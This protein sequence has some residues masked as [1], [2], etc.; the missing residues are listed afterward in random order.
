MSAQHCLRMLDPRFYL[1]WQLACLAALP[2]LSMGWILQATPVNHPPV[3][4]FFLPFEGVPFVAG[5][6]LFFQATADDPEDAVLQPSAFNWRIELHRGSVT[7][8]VLESVRGTTNGW[9]EI[10]RAPE[11]SPGS[12]Y[13]VWLTVTD[14][15]GLSTS[16]FRDVFPRTSVFSLQ[17]DPPGLPL[18]LDG[19]RVETSLAITGV[20]GVTRSLGVVS[21]V[22]MG[23]STYEFI[24]WSDRGAPEHEILTPWEPLVYWITVGVG[25]RLPGNPYPGPTA[26]PWR[27]ELLA[28]ETVVASE[29]GGPVPWQGAFQDANLNLNTEEL[30][31]T[32]LS[33]PLRLR[34][35]AASSVP[36]A[37]LD[38]DDVRVQVNGLSVNGGELSFESPSL[39]DGVL[40]EGPGLVGGWEMALNRGASCG[41]YNPPGSTYTGAGGGFEFPFTTLH[42]ANC[43]YLFTGTNGETPTL[44]RTL[45]P[46]IG[47]NVYTARFRA[48]VPRTVQIMALGDSIT[49]GGQGFA[50]YRYPLWFLLR[51]AGFDVDF[52]GRDPAVYGGNHPGNPDA[53]FYPNYYSTFDRDHEGHWGDRTQD[54][55]GLL[56]D[57]LAGDGPDIVLLHVGTDDV[58]QYGAF[59]VDSTLGNLPYI[60]SRLRAARMQVTVLLAQIIPIGTGSAYAVN[61]PLIPALNQRIARLATELDTPASRVVLVDQ[62]TGYDLAS[63]VQVDGVHPNPA[64]EGF[65]ATN[66]FRALQPVLTGTLPSRP[67]AVVSIRH[68]GPRVVLSWPVAA[69][70]YALETSPDL[71][72]PT[73]SRLVTGITSDG[74]Q[75]SLSLSPDQA[76]AQRFFRLTL[77]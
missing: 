6:T 61:A 70:A 48:V 19:Q 30:Q 46:A 39:A 51:G 20:V 29:T 32:Q 36:N 26:A 75:K 72:A 14:S 65:L 37:H 74:T 2:C 76:P 62:F 47:S 38:F 59:G 34:L 31:P 33:Q 40:A 66:W 45:V 50:S 35:S 17:T 15:E 21:P 60:I 73:W 8:I 11:I 57:A 68:D 4:H 67:P 28:G 16:E 63:M 42:G 12:W 52:V 18:R 69:G 56:D 41:I 5:Q 64:G 55:R 71:K 27:I 77:E 25:R 43:G 58:G 44:T 7:D 53:N 49:Q 1:R 23:T 9:Y 24:G 10:P 3:P 13:R 22:T 54:V